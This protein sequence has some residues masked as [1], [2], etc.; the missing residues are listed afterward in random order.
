MGKLFT[1]FYRWSRAVDCM[2]IGFLSF[3]NPLNRSSFSGT[4]Y[5]AYEALR[6][7]P[8][9]HVSILASHYHLQEN[10]RQLPLKVLSKISLG[11]INSL[12]WVEELNFNDCLSA[13]KRDLR[14]T[15]FDVVVAFVSSG[16]I[17]QLRSKDYPPFVL[18][19]DATVKYL[20]EAYNHP[21]KPDDFESEYRAIQN[22]SR[23]VY[24]SDFIANRA[25]V[26]YVS[27]LSKNPEK[28]AVV[29]FGPNLEIV[30]QQIRDRGVSGP[31]HLLFVGREWHRKGGDIAL[32]TLE[33]LQ[34]NHLNAHLTIIGSNP[35]D[36]E[37]RPNVTVIPY[38]D[39]SKPEQRQQ[40]FDILNRS[41]FLL[42]PSRADCTPMVIAEANAFGVPALV[43]DIG[44]I[45][46]LVKPGV[47]GYLFASTASGSE[48]GDVA[49]QIFAD[50]QAYQQLSQTSRKEYETRLNWDAWAQQIY[51]LSR[52]CVS[53]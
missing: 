48:Y 17:S 8:Q 51:H 32:A 25:A 31:L 3:H 45:G 49:A 39:K 10:R 33:Y 11:K 20:E 34:A 18:V 50:L 12:S 37:G 43:S 16:L 44:G 14:R 36:A 21:T 2:K 42:V 41:H 38:L 46:T 26:E 53:T 24:S 47:N 40:Y 4:T 5:Y 27:T 22:S 7:L 15:P 9:T 6:R 13:V 23:V 28:V 19:T 35:K 52:E 1:K 30:P 29:P